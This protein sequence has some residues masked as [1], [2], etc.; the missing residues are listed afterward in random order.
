M[1]KPA[2]PPTATTSDSAFPKRPDA[3][4]QTRMPDLPIED[5]LPDLK[6]ALCERTEAVLQ[7]PTGAGKTTRVPLA[8]LGED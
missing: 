4:T 7:A 5:V 2:A 8:L 6:A 3:H 1:L